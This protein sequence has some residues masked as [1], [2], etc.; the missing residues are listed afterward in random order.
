MWPSPR[1]SATSSPKSSSTPFSSYSSLRYSE[2]GRCLERAEELVAAVA[3]RHLDAELRERRRRL[4]P[5]EVRADD[6][7]AARLGGAL[8]NGRR[9]GERAQ[10]EDAAEVG[11]GDFERAR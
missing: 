2:Y 10:R 8:A 1:I 11:A 3:E 5:D 6:E 7:G 9:V 4:Q